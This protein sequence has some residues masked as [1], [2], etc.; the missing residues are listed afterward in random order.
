MRIGIGL[1][2]HPFKRGRACVLGGVTIP[3]EKGLDGHSD[4]D[5]CIH[6]LIDA[7]LSACRLDDIGAYFPPTD[8]SLTG[9]SSLVLLEKVAALVRT[10]GF[11]IVDCDLVIAADAPRISPHRSAMRA[12]M[13]AALSID[14]EQIGI[15]A[16]TCEGLGF[17]GRREG[18]V[19]QAV[20]LLD[21]AAEAASAAPVLS[22][23]PT[24]APAASAPETPAPAVMSSAP[25]QPVETPTAQDS[26]RTSTTHT[27]DH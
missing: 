17:V 16:T 21:T 11:E 10:H 12:A 20:A 14:V 25:A 19:A 26:A 22:T 5:V 13:A 27:P 6:A 3:Y 7:L 18:I 4:A 23:C 9:I 24:S 15:K 8:P 1:D 2:V